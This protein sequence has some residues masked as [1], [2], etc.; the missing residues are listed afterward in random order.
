[1]RRRL[2]I[3][4]CVVGLALL[5]AVP[6]PLPGEI[7]PWQG[8][9]I[10]AAGPRWIDRAAQAQAESG[11]NPRAVSQVKGKDGQWHPCAYGLTQF[12]PPTWAIW[13]KGKDPYDPAAS[14]DA[15]HRYMLWL[16]ARCGGHLNPALGAYNAGLGSV[17]KA[18]RVAASLGLPGEDAWLQALPRVTGEHARETQG[19]I[20]H[21]TT[22]RARIRA[23]LPQE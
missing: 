13:G 12:T 17:Q 5:A 19:Y 18:Q 8:L 4:A 6:R 10:A 16:E 2:I 20:V 1:M 15:Q 23:C 3:P 22:F 9:F 21:N 7:V 11:F 14:I